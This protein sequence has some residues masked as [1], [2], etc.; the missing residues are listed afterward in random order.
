MGKEVPSP[1]EECLHPSHGQKWSLA[2][3]YLEHNNKEWLL[4]PKIMFSFKHTEFKEPL[5][6][7]EDVLEAEER[8]ELE[9][10]ESS[11]HG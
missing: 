7:P 8:P 4:L 9:A 1:G 11:A 3:S 2:C 10:G 5:S 6:Q